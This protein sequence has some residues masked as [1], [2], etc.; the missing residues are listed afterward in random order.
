MSEKTSKRKKI[1]I[2]IVIV[3]LVIFVIYNIVWA[4][5]Y[6][7]L[8]RPYQQDVG[9]NEER[10]DYSFSDGKFVYYAGMPDYLRFNFNLAIT[11]VIPIVD[12]EKGTREDGYY[13]DMLIWPKL[14]GENK[15]GVTIVYFKDGWPEF[16]LDMYLDKNMKPVGD[17]S[18]EEMQIYNDTIDYIKNLYSLAKEMWPSLELTVE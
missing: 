14:F 17:L 9:Y 1:L 8:C 15:Y 3:V 16:A 10:S 18:D 2:R 12:P 11:Q 4:C 13:C 7:F 5:F 6:F